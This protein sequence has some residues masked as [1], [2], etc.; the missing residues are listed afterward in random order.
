MEFFL[1]HLVFEALSVL[2]CFAM[3]GIDSKHPS[4]IHQR[5]YH[6][7]QKD[8]NAVPSWIEMLHIDEQIQAVAEISDLNVARHGAAHLLVTLEFRICD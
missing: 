7:R 1:Q 4:M 2:G 3:D 5:L 6:C 8:S